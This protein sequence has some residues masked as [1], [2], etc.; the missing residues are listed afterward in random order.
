MG[1]LAF[2]LDD[3][4]KLRLELAAARLN[5]SAEEILEDLVHGKIEELEEMANLAARMESG[6]ESSQVAPQ[7]EAL[8]GAGIIL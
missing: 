4:L 2:N 7:V 8:V 6:R 5:L 1:K 3:G